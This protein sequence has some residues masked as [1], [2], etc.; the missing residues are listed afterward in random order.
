MQ[1]IRNIIVIGASAGGIPAIKRMLSG[2][3]GEMDIVVLVV[4]HMSRKSNSKIIVEGFQRNTS[5][6]CRVA[7]EGKVLKKGYLY[8]APTDYHLMV[9]NNK[10]TISQGPHEN[11][12]RPSIDVMFRSVAVNY[13]NRVIGI[14]LT[15]MLDD[16][17]SGMVAVKKS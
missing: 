4:L 1:E 2:L 10:L 9:K 14:I 12:Y 13:R 6:A 11:K 3:T 16:G 15:G 5:L 17:T 7:E 8:L